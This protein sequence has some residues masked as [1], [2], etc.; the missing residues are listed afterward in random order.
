M[1]KMRDSRS[2]R[3]CKLPYD[4]YV[5]AVPRLTGNGSEI[6]ISRSARPDL[7]PRKSANQVWFRLIDG[8]PACL[9]NAAG[10]LRMKK[11]CVLVLLTLVAVAWSLQSASALPPFNVAWKAKYLEG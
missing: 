9:T 10:E 11:V 3:R 5:S 4:P 2:Q 6:V 8:V 7:L 1:R